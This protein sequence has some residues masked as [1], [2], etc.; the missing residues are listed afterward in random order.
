MFQPFFLPC[1]QEAK[2]YIGYTDDSGRDSGAVESLKN[3]PASLK[4]NIC[5]EFSSRTI[6]NLDLKSHGTFFRQLL[7]ADAD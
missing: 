2:G 4:D 3:C 5:F 7:Q 1:F 6:I